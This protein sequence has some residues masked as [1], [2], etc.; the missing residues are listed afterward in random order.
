LPPLLVFA[1]ASPNRSDER[2]FPQDDRWAA[3]RGLA[4]ARAGGRLLP[5]IVLRHARRGLA[6]DRAF[7]WR[8]R[9]VG[10]TAGNRF[11]QLL[12]GVADRSWR[13]SL[14]SCPPFQ[15]RSRPMRDFR[16]RRSR[17]PLSLSSFSGAL[18]S[19]RRRSR[20]ENRER[21]TPARNDAR[22]CPTH[23]SRS[24]C[25]RNSNRRRLAVHIDSTGAP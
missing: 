11:R 15:D 7:A 22:E 14:S 25:R 16:W 21:R 24:R 19:P 6:V 3:R 20:H 5:D 18:A 12:D 2:H 13:A 10:Q 1:C 8:N 4:V 17:S 9:P 23:K